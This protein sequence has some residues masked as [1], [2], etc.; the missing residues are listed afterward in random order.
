MSHYPSSPHQ[1]NASGLIS[2][3]VHHIL[4]LVL[5]ARATPPSLLGVMNKVGGMAVT[6]GRVTSGADAVCP[7]DEVASP[8]VVDHSLVL[9][10]GGRKRFRHLG[11]GCLYPNDL[12]VDG[13][14]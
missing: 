1:E 8:G 13:I 10:L 5:H 11:L 2:R 4:D 3:P 6:A 9:L 7:A 14:G 12:V